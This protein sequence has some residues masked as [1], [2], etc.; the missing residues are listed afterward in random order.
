[1][2]PDLPIG[3][4]RFEHAEPKSVFNRHASDTSEALDNGIQ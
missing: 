3:D 1:M 2:P 4:R